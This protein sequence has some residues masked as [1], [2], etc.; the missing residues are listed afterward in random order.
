MKFKRFKSVVFP[1]LF[2]FFASPASAR[3]D[4]GIFLFS[5]MMGRIN[6]D[7][8]YTSPGPAGMHTLSD[9]GP[10]YALMMMYT[11][12]Q[13]TLGSM[14]HFSKL[15]NSIENGYMFYGL[16]YFGTETNI[17]PMMGLYADYINVFTRTPAADI[18]PLLSLN[19]NTSIWAFHPVV[20]LSF[21]VGKQNI[22]PFVGYFN[23]QVETS[24]ASEGMFV[25]GQKRNGFTADS[26]AVM[27]YMTVGVKA[28]FKVMHF[29]RFDTKVYARMKNGES[30]LFTARN[31]LDFLLSRQAG[32][33]IK[34]DYFDDTYEKNTFLLAGPVF[35]F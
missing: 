1:L 19:V 25:A 29:I 24:L 11:C 22:A 33:S 3:D 32:L 10:I 9:A 23:E 16:Y 20:G 30:P 17:R 35:V 7:I 8:Q 4:N 14:G 6:S 27:D 12:P 26:S 2:V 13:Y 21:K 28:E 31:R 5:P 18:A 15:D 34:Y